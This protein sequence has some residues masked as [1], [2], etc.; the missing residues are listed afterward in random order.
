MMKGIWFDDVHSFE[1]L[2][3]VLSEVNI[4][5]AV[6]KTNFVEI[7]GGDGS[8]DLT[9]AHGEVKYNSREGSFTFTA[10]PSDDFEEKKKEVSNLLNGKRCKIRLDKD[11]DYYYQGRCGVNEYKSDKNVH[12][13]VVTFVVDPYKLKRNKTINTA[14]FCGKNLF[15]ND[16]AQYTKPRDYFVCPIV[17]EWGKTYTASVKLTGTSM[18]NIV[19]AVAPYGDVYAELKEGMLSL[20]KI[21]GSYYAKTTFTVDET[22]TAPKLAIYTTE[23]SVASVFQNYDIQLEVG[24]DVTDYEEYTPINETQEVTLTNGRKKVV[25]T[26]ICT[27]EITLSSDSLQTDLNPGTHKLLDLQLH[28]G[29][30]TVSL[31]G[32]GSVAFVYQEGDL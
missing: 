2:N 27:N 15:V 19:V 18:T 10:F 12:Q 1:H 30:R 13:I 7:P 26:I 29:E 6:P 14:Y 3:L 11:P 9:E 21:G 16:S 23:E 32:S 17:F 28:E 24:S 5:P 25:P 20:I 8:V 22:W 31:S 4:P